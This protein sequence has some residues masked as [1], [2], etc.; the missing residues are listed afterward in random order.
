MKVAISEFSYHRRGERG[1]TVLC[2]PGGSSMVTGRAF[3]VLWFL[4]FLCPLPVAL[5]VGA[6]LA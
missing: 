6:L 3:L 1:L 2:D 5:P 4:Q